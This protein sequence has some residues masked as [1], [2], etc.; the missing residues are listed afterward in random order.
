MI[1]K[2]CP[3]FLDFAHSVLP[4][5]LC[6]IRMGTKGLLIALLVLVVHS[7][8]VAA[9]SNQRLELSSNKKGNIFT[10]NQAQLL[11]VISEPEKLVS[12]AVTLTDEK[13]QLLKEILIPAGRARLNIEL[14]TKGYYDIEAQAQFSDGVQCK[15]RTTAGV[16]GPLLDESLRM[17][18]HL[19]LASH[20]ASD[21]FMI[22]LSGGHW[23]RMFRPLN[24]RTF[25]RKH[26]FDTVE[27]EDKPK[28]VEDKDSA[29]ICVF[30]WGMPYWLIGM[31][32]KETNY[33]YGF[34]T[35]VRPPDNWADLEVLAKF[36]AYTFPYKYY[37]VYNEPMVRWEGTLEELVK[38]HAVMARGIKAVR[39]DAHVM[40][41]AFCNL[42]KWLSWDC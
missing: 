11:L 40:G 14:P 15:K 2:D 38:F 42:R 17:Q 23:E 26:V 32:D 6:S 34:K 13:G 12:A 19:G 30:A 5:L 27:S 41:P 37:E 18:S 36:L 1:K 16:L 9:D 33:K 4:M 3:R 21:S 20:Y 29:A 8:V 24:Y 10:T 7:S 35:P 22:P 39:P 28:P 25:T 31:E